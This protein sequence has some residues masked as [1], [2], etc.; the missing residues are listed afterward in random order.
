MPH[1]IKLCVCMGG[2]VKIKVLTKLVDRVTTSVT[3]SLCI[4][5]LLFIISM[6]SYTDMFICQTLLQSLPYLN[7]DFLANKLTG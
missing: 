6:V 4:E 1:K 5:R 7:I 2:G 3:A